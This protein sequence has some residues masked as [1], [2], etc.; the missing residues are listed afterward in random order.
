MRPSFTPS[1]LTHDKECQLIF[2]TRANITMASTNGDDG[3]H[4]PLLSPPQPP[5]PPL[6][7]SPDESRDGY[8]PY[9]SFWTP[10]RRARTSPSM[11]HHHG[12]SHGNALSTAWNQ[13]ISFLKIPLII[14]IFSVV[15]P[16][17][18][19]SFRIFQNSTDSTF[20]P[21][22]ASPSERAQNAFQESYQNDWLNPMHPSLLVVLETSTNHSLV[23]KTSPLYH[24][25][26]DFSLGLARHL[27]E[28]C[29]KIH[30]TDTECL[31]EPW[32]QVIS[33]YSL[34][35]EK[36]HWLAN[37]L[38]TGD[39]VLISVQYLLAENATNTRERVYTLMDVVQAYGDTHVPFNCTVAYTGIKWFQSDLMMAT[40][41]DLRR[42]DAIVLPLALVLLGVVLP[43]ARSSL[44]W[45]I[46]FVTMI[47]TV[48]CWS[49]IMRFVA[50]HIQ[51]TQ[52]TPSIMTSLTLGMVSLVLLYI[53]L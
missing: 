28:T 48:C 1:P 16:V 52:F 27:N 22:P 11:E 18:I 41:T 26:R 50:Q 25:A 10:G 44:V 13:G 4:V 31:K 3:K 51:I 33:Y 21:I 23:Q 34:E 5:A 43:N 2:F 39:V 40:K 37:T 32:I 19:M 14:L 12:T 35:E 6:E 53:L 36:L 45:I 49:I 15:W 20:H 46:P 38:T 30:E 17:G 47:T 8:S 9:W 42:M 29:W 7:E 24:P